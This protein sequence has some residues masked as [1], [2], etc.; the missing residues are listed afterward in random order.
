MA[1]SGLAERE[2]IMVAVAAAAEAVVV[3]GGRSGGTG[4]AF[5]S[6]AFWGFRVEQRMSAA[7]G[8]SY[9]GDEATASWLFRC[10]CV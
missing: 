1:F 4:E 3:V 9:N 8:M 2:G 6:F 5:E 10:V 7:C